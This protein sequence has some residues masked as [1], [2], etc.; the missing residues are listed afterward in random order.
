M[1]TR[2]IGVVIQREQ[3]HG[4]SCTL[5]YEDSEWR[6]TFIK[7]FSSSQEARDWSD[8]H[9]V[10]MPQYADRMIKRAVR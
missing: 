5:I 3:G 8:R 9:A 6:Q 1:D 2:L 10:S 4:Y 7:Y